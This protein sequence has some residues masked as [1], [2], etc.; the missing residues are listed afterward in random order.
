MT[1]GLSCIRGPNRAALAALVALVTLAVAGCEAGSGLVG[2][3]TPAA[4]STS[5]APSSSSPI[6]PS[7]A[8][9]AGTTAD[10]CHQSGVTYCVLNP[11]VTQAII[12]Q[13][14]CVS[15]WTR[16][17]RPPESYTEQL[18]RQQIAAEGL[19]GGLSAYEE[20]HRM[21]LE[22]GGAPSDP[23][24]LSPQSPASPNPKDR[25]ESR[26]R[27]AVCAGTMTLAAAQ[28]ELVGTW[29]GPYPTYTH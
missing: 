1:R 11:A 14:I 21:P 27:E 4:S 24:N 8:A 16:T 2:T 29:L 13:T 15:G 9:P 3:D 20:D 6:P 19:P 18:K 7:A 10:A 22:L 28:S 26:L 25:D 17:V 23:D 5:A 12:G